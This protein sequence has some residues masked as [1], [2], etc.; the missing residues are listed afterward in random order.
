[1]TASPPLLRACR[2]R[3]RAGRRR[4]SRQR[5]GR[6]PGAGRPSSEAS[7]AALDVEDLHFD[8]AR[9]LLVTIRRS[10]PTRSRQEPRSGAVCA[11][12]DLCAVRALLAWL[13]TAG[14]H[15]GPVSGRCAAATHSPIT[16]S[17]PVRR[18]ISSTTPR[19]PGSAPRECPGTRYAPATQP[20][21]RDR[22]HREST[23]SPTS[24]ATTTSPSY[25]ATS[26]PPRRTTTSGRELEVATGAVDERHRLKRVAVGVE[27]PWAVDED[28][29]ALGP[30]DRDVEAVRVEEEIDAAR[31]VLAGRAGHRVEDD[32]RLL[33]LEAVDRADADTRGHVLADAVHGEV[34]RRD[35]EDVRLHERARDAFVVG[36]GRACEQ[37]AAGG[38]DRGGLLRARLAPAC[39]FDGDASADRRR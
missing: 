33:A 24:H 30:G 7:L 34:V 21:R 17:R 31:H 2:P 5:L 37:V 9:G 11:G 16:G 13:E 29:E 6:R 28:G 36:D 4:R 8:A 19:P 32:R 25:A 15:R 27:Q 23:R 22:R 35:D 14:I 26:A 10:K 38:R 39:V 1:M 3:T 12:N 18:A 20:P